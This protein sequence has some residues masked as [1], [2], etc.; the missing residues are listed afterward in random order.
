MRNSTALSSRQERI[1]SLYGVAGTSGAVDGVGAAARVLNPR[2]LTF[3]V[4][5][6]T[7]FVSDY[8]NAAIRRVDPATGAVQTFA[9]VMG[10]AGTS[11]GVGTAARFNAPFGITGDGDALY[12]VDQSNNSVRRIDLAT[13]MVTTLFGT[14]GSANCNDF[15]GNVPGV[16]ICA[17]EGITASSSGLFLFGP[18]GIRVA[19]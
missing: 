10:S 1:R 7:L 13:Q 16:S 5:S 18:N 14:T 2:G 8:S 6:N 9:G 12:V 4:T 15:D 17:P 3:D 11:D 19:R